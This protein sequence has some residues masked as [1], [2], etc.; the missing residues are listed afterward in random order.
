MP[1]WASRLT[2]EVVSV[3]TA[4]GTGCIVEFRVLRGAQ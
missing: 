4:L 3:L 2:L 1:S